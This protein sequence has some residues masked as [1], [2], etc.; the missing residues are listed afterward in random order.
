MS[1]RRDRSFFVFRLFAALAAAN[2]YQPAHVYPVHGFEHYR[3][4]DKLNR[5]HNDYLGDS[6][7]KQRFVIHSVKEIKPKRSYKS[8][9]NKLSNTRGEKH[10]QEAPFFIEKKPEY[11][12]HSDLGEGDRRVYHAV[13]L[14]YA[15]DDIR[16]T[17]HSACACRSVNISGDDH[18]DECQADLDA[19]ARSDGEHC[20]ND[21]KGGKDAQHSQMDG[22]LPDVDSGAGCTVFTHKKTSC[23]S[24]FAVIIGSC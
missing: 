2:G 10:P 20:D 4:H 17:C 18:R 13:R 7:D 24:D 15:A 12:P 1:D 22:R 9:D 8:T 14:D 5:K 16:K 19:V 21:A 3:Y 23:Y 11:Y 6:G